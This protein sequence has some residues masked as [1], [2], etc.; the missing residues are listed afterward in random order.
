MHPEPGASTPGWEALQVRGILLRTMPPLVLGKEVFP[1][2]S[3][4]TAVAFS[5]LPLEVTKVVWVVCCDP[6]RPTSS[7]RL[8]IGQ[9]SKKSR[10]GE[11]SPWEF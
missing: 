6:A 8:W 7:E 1:I 5:E 4:R 2:T 10:A 11:V 3:V 9:V